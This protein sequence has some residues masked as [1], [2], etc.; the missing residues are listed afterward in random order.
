MNTL[1]PIDRLD[2]IK[3]IPVLALDSVEAGLKMCELLVRHGLPAAEI[4]FR[5]AAAE[6]TIRQAAKEFPEM[7]LGAGTVLKPDQL[8]RA[9]DAGARFAVAPGCN[10]TVVKAASAQG[11]PFIPGI[12][13]PSEIEQ[14]VELGCTTLK[15]FPA[16][17][18]G[19]VKM[20]QCFLA[21]YRQLGLRFM[22]TGGIKLENAGSYLAIPEV[23][24]VGGTWLAS[25]A[26]IRDAAASNDWS[27]IILAIQE[28]ADLAR[29]YSKR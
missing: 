17:A 29:K 23:A 4:T 24:A 9:I 27:S 19:G 5:T 13:T 25:S 8:Q 2:A 1:S 20:L 14:A 21:P 10:P 7:F 3:I 18:S 28:A 11:F 22:P 26:A 15:F 6:E 16:E 12:C